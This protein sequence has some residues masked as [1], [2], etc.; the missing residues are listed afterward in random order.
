[1]LS[2]YIGRR[3]E[4]LEHILLLTVNVSERAVNIFVY[5]YVVFSNNVKNLRRSPYRI[6][7]S[8]QQYD[9]LAETLADL[10]D[11]T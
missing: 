1:M 7:W 9:L 4:N 11:P 3:A 8:F 6:R 2:G 10:Y 5:V